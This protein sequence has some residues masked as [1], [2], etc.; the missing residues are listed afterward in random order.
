MPYRNGRPVSEAL[1]KF[2]QPLQLLVLAYSFGGCSPENRIAR[3][4]VAWSSQKGVVRQASDPPTTYTDFQSTLGVC[5]DADDV[6]RELGFHHESHVHRGCQ[7]TQTLDS[8]ADA[9]R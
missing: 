1:N 9:G 3:I 2:R 6:D 4:A 5:F 8:G 7:K